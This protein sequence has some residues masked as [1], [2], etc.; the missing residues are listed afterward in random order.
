MIHKVD[1]TGGYTFVVFFNVFSLNVFFTGQDLLEEK[2][3]EKK[4]M[5]REYQKQIQL[6]QKEHKKEVDV[7]RIFSHT[8]LNIKKK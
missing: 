7:S 8:F 5:G 2:L 6:L 4:Q 3:K 1:K